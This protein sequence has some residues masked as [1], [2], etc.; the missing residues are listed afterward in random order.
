MKK[1]IIAVLTITLFGCSR[2]LKVTYQ[3]DPSGA[4]LYQG[5]TMMGETPLSLEYKMTS[6]D[7]KLGYKVLTGTKVKWASGATAEVSTLNADIKKYGLTQQ[8]TFQRPDSYPGRE[9]DVNNALDKQRLNIMQQ[10]AQAQDGQ[11]TWQM[12]NTINQQQQY[13]RKPVNCASSLTGSTVY[14]DCR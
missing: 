11:A 12:I 9:I 1:I 4:T 13:Y 3:S 10:Q 6:E 8:F 5:A 7:I 2:T 14:T